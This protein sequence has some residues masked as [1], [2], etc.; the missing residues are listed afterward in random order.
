MNKPYHADLP[1]GT[2]VIG[3]SWEEA[4]PRYIA[5]MMMKGE[6]VNCDTRIFGLSHTNW[7]G[8]IV[9]QQGTVSIGGKVYINGTYLPQCCFWTLEDIKELESMEAEQ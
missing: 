5:Y 7:N 1:K 4:R 6:D 9:N 3:M 8:E 2:I